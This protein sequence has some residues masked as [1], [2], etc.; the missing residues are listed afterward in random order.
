MPLEAPVST[1]TFDSPLIRGISLSCCLVVTLGPLPRVVA[2][3]RLTLMR[4]LLILIVFASVAVAA[5]PRMARRDGVERGKLPA[6]LRPP[7]SAPPG[8]LAVIGLR[9]GRW[10]TIAARP[11][12]KM[13]A[14]SDPGGTIQFWSL[15][16]FK[17]VAKVNHK[18]V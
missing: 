14:A 12:G 11:D 15:P 6:R 13:I 18:Q 3:C 9:D 1:A 4:T 17:P 2:V 10:D 7:M 16:D 8:T 5:E